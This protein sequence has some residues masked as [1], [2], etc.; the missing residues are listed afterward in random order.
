MEEKTRLA[1][2]VR[3]KPQV[4]E[5]RHGAEPSIRELIFNYYADHDMEN[6]EQLTNYYLSELEKMAG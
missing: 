2:L 3:F 1:R 4:S 5:L 6:P